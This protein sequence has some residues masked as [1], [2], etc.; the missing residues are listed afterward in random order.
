MLARTV[1]FYWCRF[2]SSK[3]IFSVS[4]TRVYSELLLMSPTVIYFYY[5]PI[6]LQ[7]PFATP[8]ISVCCVLRDW[9]LSNII[10]KSSFNLKLQFTF[11][12]TQETVVII[13]RNT[14]SLSFN[15]I[16]EVH[17]TSRSYFQ[18]V[19]QREDT[20]LITMRLM[21]NDRTQGKI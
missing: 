12:T 9:C 18:I 15:V 5:I 3:H 11:S 16:S 4:A 20:K 8:V 14:R 13:A 6:W 17:T 7:S 2:W 19:T 1:H 21:K 10:N